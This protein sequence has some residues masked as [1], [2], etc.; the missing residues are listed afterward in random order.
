ML[1]CHLQLCA[2]N[3]KLFTT[4]A[5]NKVKPSSNWSVIKVLKGWDDEIWDLLNLSSQWH[6]SQPCS[7]DRL[8]CALWTQGICSVLSF[9]TCAIA[10]SFGCLCW[11]H[12]NEDTSSEIFPALNLCPQGGWRIVWL[13]E[14]VCILGESWLQ[15]CI[16]I[17]TVGSHYL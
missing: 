3:L 10:M 2:H 15:D 6:L 14:K 13:F 8:K 11:K 17:S 4:R 1:H 7:E 9:I 5:R 12:A 16:T